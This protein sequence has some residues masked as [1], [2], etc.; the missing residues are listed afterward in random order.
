MAR[1]HVPPKKKP[2]QLLRA[3]DTPASS[4]RELSEPLNGDDPGPPSRRANYAC[5]LSLIKILYWLRHLIARPM[6][7]PGNTPPLTDF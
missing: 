6:C 2:A 3:S 7:L 1:F 5:A 4:A